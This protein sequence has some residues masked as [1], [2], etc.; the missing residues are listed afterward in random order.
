MQ[1]N[2]I[3]NTRTYPRNGSLLAPYPL[4]K[5]PMNGYKL[6]LASACKTRGAPTREAI[7][8]D[9]V[10]AKHPAKIKYPVY[11]IFAIF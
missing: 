1:A 6:S 7:A 9:R 10:A 11:D 8:E 5:N 4:L 2:D 3:R